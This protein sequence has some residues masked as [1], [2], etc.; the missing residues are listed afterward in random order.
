M[1][2]LKVSILAHKPSSNK[3]CVIGLI[4]MEA[5]LP[6]LSNRGFIDF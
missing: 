6:V 4:F 1:T 2:L 3:P 5:Y